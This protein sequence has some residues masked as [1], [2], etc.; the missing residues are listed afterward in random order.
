M[1]RTPPGNSTSSLI[2]AAWSPKT[3]AMP[4]PIEST[5]PVS[6]M[7][8]SRPYSRISRFRMSVIS[9]GLMFI[10]TPGA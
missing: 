1:P 10:G 4:S 9:L 5:E 3:R 8:I 6:A 7:S 2:M